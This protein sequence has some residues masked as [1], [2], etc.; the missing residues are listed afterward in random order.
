MSFKCAN[1][2]L[3]GRQVEADL[4]CTIVVEEEKLEKACWCVCKECKQKFEERIDRPYKDQ[5]E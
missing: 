1:C 3:C 5:I 4:M 2:E